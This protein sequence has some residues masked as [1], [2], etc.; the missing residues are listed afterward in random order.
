MPHYSVAAG[1]EAAVDAEEAF[2]CMSYKHLPE[3]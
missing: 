3:E 2:P 1:L